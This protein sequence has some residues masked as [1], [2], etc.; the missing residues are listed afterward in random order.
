MI[1]RVVGSDV[2]GG[3][4]GGAKDDDQ[5]PRPPDGGA[6]TAGTFTVKVILRGVGSIFHTI[7]TERILIVWDQFTSMVYDLT[8]IQTA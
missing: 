2:V 6:S 8:D 5:P 1:G 4:A 7:S 3:R